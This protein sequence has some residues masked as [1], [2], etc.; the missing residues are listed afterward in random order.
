M[1]QCVAVLAIVLLVAPALRAA[2]VETKEVTFKSGEDEVKGF[3]A[4][5]KGKG[6]YPGIVV[7]QEW[8]GLNDW[9]KDQ[10]KRIAAEGYVALAPDLY[11]GKVADN[12]NLA[13]QLM[14][15]LPRDRA[16]R[17]LKGALDYLAGVEQVDKNKLGSIGW[18]MGGGYSL[19]LALDDP[20][21]TACVVCYGAP[22]TEKERLKKLKAEVLGIYGAKDKGIPVTAVRTFEKE[23]KELGQ[24]GRVH[25]FPD[26]GHGFMRPGN[27]PMANPAYREA[28]ARE[29]WQ[30]IDEFLA[31][32]LKK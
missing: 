14:R 5:P 4:M 12:P 3:L 2:D 31:K 13:G 21:V 23:M 29:A 11:R 15:G 17:D 19:E 7:I 26:A 6:P 1:K 8:W 9:M 16:M 10:A 22:V 30:E 32:R 25:I 20:R 27:G 18:C 24:P 28:D